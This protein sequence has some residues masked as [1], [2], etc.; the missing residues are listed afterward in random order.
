MA[1]LDAPPSIAPDLLLD[2]P[3]VF[4]SDPS[5][6]TVYYPCLKVPAPTGTEQTVPP[7]GPIAGIRARTDRGRGLCKAPPTRPSWT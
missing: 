1:I 6:A 4:G 5:F 3:P 7:C 2:Q